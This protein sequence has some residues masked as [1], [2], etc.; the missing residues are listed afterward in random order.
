[1]VISKESLLKLSKED[2]VDAIIKISEANER[3]IQT[4]DTVMN[5]VKILYPRINKFEE[6]FNSIK[7]EITIIRKSCESEEEFEEKMRVYF[8]ELK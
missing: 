2:L 1:M 3:M 6:D 4:I 7:K 8:K 5:G